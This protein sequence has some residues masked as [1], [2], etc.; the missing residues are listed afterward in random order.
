[1]IRHRSVLEYRH[2]RYLKV[3]LV[4]SLGAG[5]AYWWHDPPVKPYGGT[6]LGYS[7]GTV[8]A[9]LIVW[10]M[11]F[12]VRKRRYA[13]GRNVLRGWLSAHVYL[14]TAL[15]LVALLH[16]GFQFG[17]NLHTLALV[18]MLA[19]IFSGFFM[20]FLGAFVGRSFVRGALRDARSEKLV[21]S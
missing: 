10:L 13:G 20:M 19:V 3:A 4:L 9:L 1:M 18:L 16:C 21:T 5:V 6:W 2:F 15:I 17:W 8:G 12:G 11:L 7:L 14:G